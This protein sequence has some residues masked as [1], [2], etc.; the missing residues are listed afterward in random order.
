MS[1]TTLDQRDALLPRQF[2]SGF[3]LDSLCGRVRHVHMRNAAINGCD[4]GPD[5]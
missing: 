2:E 4:H 5:D 3:A 1:V